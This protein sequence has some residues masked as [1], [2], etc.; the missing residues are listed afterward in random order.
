MVHNV[1]FFCEFLFFTQHCVCEVYPC[2]CLEQLLSFL[3]IGCI[4]LLDCC[5]Y[6]SQQSYFSEHMPLC[7]VWL[8]L[9]SEDKVCFFSVLNLGWPYKCFDIDFGGNDIM[10]VLDFSSK[11]TCSFLSCL[12]TS[13][14]YHAIVEEP[15]KL[16][17]LSCGF[18]VNKLG[19]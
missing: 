3:Y 2:C 10:Q 7:H 19:N 18:I 15:K 5:N 8:L 4:W 12:P 11:N 14:Y 6:D 13:F 17:N 16:T 9:L 1:Y